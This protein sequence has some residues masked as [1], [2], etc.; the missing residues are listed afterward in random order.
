MDSVRPDSLLVLKISNMSKADSYLVGGHVQEL[1]CE[2]RTKQERK[3]T[4]DSTGN[5]SRAAPT[6]RGVTGTI[7]KTRLSHFETECFERE[8][9]VIGIRTAISTSLTA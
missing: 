2:S 8:T 9:S 7:Q 6:S 5:W 4:L 1:I 3:G